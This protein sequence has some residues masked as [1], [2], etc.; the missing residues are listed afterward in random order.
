MHRKNV[1]QTVAYAE[2]FHGGGV[3]SAFSGIG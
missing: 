3:H 2:T 1:F